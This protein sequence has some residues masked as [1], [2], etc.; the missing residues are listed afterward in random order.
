MSEEVEAIE[1]DGTYRAVQIPLMIKADAKPNDVRKF[2]KVVGEQ[3]SLLLTKTFL[4]DPA[5]Y[6]IDITV[7]MEKKP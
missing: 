4:K 7:T 1:D 2:N 5:N 6:D 3:I